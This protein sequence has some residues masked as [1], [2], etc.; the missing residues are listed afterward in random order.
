MAGPTTGRDWWVTQTGKLSPGKFPSLTIRPQSN[1]KVLRK[2][3]FQQNLERVVQNSR[4]IFH[5][6][7]QQHVNLPRKKRHVKSLPSTNSAPG[8]TQNYRLSDINIWPMSRYLVPFNCGV[9]L[10]YS[11]L[12]PWLHTIKNDSSKP[13]VCVKISSCFPSKKIVLSHYIMFMQDVYP[14][15]FV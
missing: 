8:K 11:Q 14:F 6:N 2:L 4:G 7:R 10:Q 3:N 9:H 15:M 12:D 13:S 5:I 1:S